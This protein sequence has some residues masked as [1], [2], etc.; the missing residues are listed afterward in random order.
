MP[1]ALVHSLAVAPVDLG[2]KPSH[3]AQAL[4]AGATVAF[5]EVHAEDHMVDG[6]TFLRHLERQRE[7]WPL[8]IHGVGL[9]IGGEGPLDQVHLGAPHGPN[10]RPTLGTK[11]PFEEAQRRDAEAISQGRRGMQELGKAL[12]L[13]PCPLC[14][15]PRHCA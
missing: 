9:S 2:L 14:C 5:V 6:G 7:R 12:W 4:A 1:T 10:A 11:N 8:S 13:S 3:V 15:P